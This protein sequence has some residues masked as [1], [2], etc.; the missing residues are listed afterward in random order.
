VI[1]YFKV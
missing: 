1:Y